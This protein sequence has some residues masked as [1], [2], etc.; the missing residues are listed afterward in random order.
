MTKCHAVTEIGMMKARAPPVRTVT[1]GWWGQL[2]VVRAW[3]GGGLSLPW[4]GPPGLP[5]GAGPG[6]TGR[7]SL[8]ASQPG[9]QPAFWSDTGG[10]RDT[11]GH[12]GPAVNTHT[13]HNDWE[14]DICHLSGEGR[15]DDDDDD[16]FPGRIF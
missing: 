11:G 6:C 9:G 13:S 3:K 7:G 2:S 10:P 1:E 16:V 15:D 14:T 8:G 12:W 5:A 4:S